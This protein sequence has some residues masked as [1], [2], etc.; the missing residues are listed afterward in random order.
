MIVEHV[1]GGQRV[2]EVS[3]TFGVAVKNIKRWL[4]QG[5]QRIK[6]GGRKVLD[7]NLDTA[8]SKW[9]IQVSLKDKVNVVT[10]KGRVKKQARQLSTVSGFKASKG[11]LDK[12]LARTQIE[13]QINAMLLGQ[14]SVEETE[15]KREETLLCS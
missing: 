4:K 15:L 13:H 6:G 1:V 5:V 14:D 7:R 3:K 9:L 11:W 12:F 2:E 10:N 8:L